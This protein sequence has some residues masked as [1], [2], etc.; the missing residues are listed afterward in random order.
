MSDKLFNN[1]NDEISQSCPA[2]GYQKVDVCVPVTVTPF[3]NAGTTFTKCC[4][5][6]RV[7]PGIAPCAGEKNAACTFTLS[8]TVCVEVP[9]EFGAVANVGDTYVDC[10]GASSE[11]I[12]I[13]CSDEVIE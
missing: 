6:P 7:T 10:L 2:V 8:Q 4:G 9:V 13:N 5:A 3:A 1:L 11:D 12:C